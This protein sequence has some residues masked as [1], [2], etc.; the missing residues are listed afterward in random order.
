MA[1]ALGNSQ[2]VEG[3]LDS[4]NL[5]VPGAY[6]V[7]MDPP[8]MNVSGGVGAFE[9]YRIVL[10]GP[11]GSSLWIYKGVI[12]YDY[13]ENGWRNSWDPS[14]PL[15]LNSGDTVKLYWNVSSGTPTPIVTMYFQ[16]QT[17]T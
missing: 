1:R 3:K 14:N 15:K 9:C 8:A 4:G 7:T 13:V 17:I 5:F 12:P 10:D 16:E 2:P 6:T 11:V